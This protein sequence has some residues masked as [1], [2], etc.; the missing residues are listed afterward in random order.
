MTANGPPAS[1][2]PFEDPAGHWNARFAADGFLFGEAPNVSLVE[3]A[4]L[5]P[6]G[7]RVLCVADGEGRNSTWLAARGC[8]VT[9]FDL[10]PVGVAKARALAVER[11]VEVDLHVASVTEWD[12]EREQFD[13]VV[14]VFVQFADPATRAAMFA[15]FARALR[16]G[17]VLLLVGYGPRQLEYRTGGPGRLEHLYDE[18]MLRAAFSGWR[19]ERLVRSDRVLHEGPGHD[20]V[21]DVVELVARR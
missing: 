1:P 11:R 13:A 19:I 16:P 2:S 15:G 18:P 9:A 8:R 7:A 14:A 21:S 10:S 5:F 20:G 6:P 12:W 17:G 3:H 4:A